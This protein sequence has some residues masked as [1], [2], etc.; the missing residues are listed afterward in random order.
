MLATVPGSTS[1]RWVVDVGHSRH[2]CLPNLAP[3]ATTPPPASPSQPEPGRTAGPAPVCGRRRPA[4]PVTTGQRAE[5]HHRAA[6]TTGPAHPSRAVPHRV[7]R[8]AVPGGRRRRCRDRQYL[9]AERG[10]CC[11]V[12]ASHAETGWR[13]HRRRP[14]VD[15]ATQPGLLAWRWSPQQC[16][17]CGESLRTFCRGCRW[18][19]WVRSS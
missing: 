12:D 2:T 8:G 11:L 15:S 16:P 18:C 7:A 5:P 14:S 13:G 3:G 9:R 1:K 17:A 4:R 19:R 10:A 6:P